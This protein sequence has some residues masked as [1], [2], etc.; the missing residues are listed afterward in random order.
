MQTGCSGPL[1]KVLG[2]PSALQ[3]A[4]IVGQWE[5]CAGCF[6]WLVEQW[7][8]CRTVAG[9]M[10]PFRLLGH[11]SANFET[12][13][14]N[15]NM[16]CF[17]MLPHAAGGGAW[18][19][20]SSMGTDQSIRP[21]PSVQQHTKRT[22]K[23]TLAKPKERGRKGITSP[24]EGSYAAGCCVATHLHDQQANTVVGP[25]RMIMCDM[26]MRIKQKKWGTKETKTTHANFL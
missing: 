3:A 13:A 26:R 11:A 17:G 21:L 2:A 5:H 20:Q 8:K 22:R 1:E 4:K 23:R 25:P 18:P 10:S 14:P 7:H 15:R 9:A 16:G 12:W 6:N 24:A 19:C